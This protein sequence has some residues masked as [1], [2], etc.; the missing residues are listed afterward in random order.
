MSNPVIGWRDA[1][2]TDEPRLKELWAEQHAL[3]AEKAPTVHSEMPDLFYPEGETHHAFY[4]FRPPILRVRVCEEDGVITS[5]RIVEAVCEV[6][7]I[8]GTQN[9]VR[10]LGRELPE[11]CHWA[12]EKGFRSGW[13]LAP[14]EF[15]K[16]IERSLRHTP[17]RVWPNLVLVGCD[18]SELGD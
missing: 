2:H 6:Q 7:V 13:G 15:V 10:S 3:F 1:T 12:R 18:F 11:E 16:P 5:F 9:S 4:P 17:L 14:R 8:G